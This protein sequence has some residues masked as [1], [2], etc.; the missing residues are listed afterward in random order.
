[1]NEFTKFELEMMLEAL[2]EARLRSVGATNAA[3]DNCI[4]LINGQLYPETVPPSRKAKCLRGC[5]TVLSTEE[6][7]HT[8]ICAY[9][10]IPDLDGYDGDL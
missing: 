5:G 6:D 1:M 10:W 7:L 3:L 4:I 2:Y 9:C 8:G